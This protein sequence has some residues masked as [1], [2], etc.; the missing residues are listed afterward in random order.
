VVED[1]PVSV[2]VDVNGNSVHQSGPAEWQQRIAAAH[3]VT[4][5]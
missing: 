3:P 1:M 4:V 2:A 5:K